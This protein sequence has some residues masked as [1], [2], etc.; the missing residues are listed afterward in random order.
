T[1][2][3][4]TGRLLLVRALEAELGDV[5]P[6]GDLDLADLDEVVPVGNDLPQRLVRVDADAGLVDVGDL[7]RLTDLQL[8][9]VERL[10]AHDRLEQR[11]LTDAVGADDA[12]DAVGRQGE[13]QAVDELAVPEALLQVPG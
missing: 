12:D 13:G 9:V 8:A 3:Q 10:E 2:G 1:T 11:G 6:R 4:H 5:G 7:D